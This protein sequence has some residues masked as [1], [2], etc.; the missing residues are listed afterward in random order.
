MKN[1]FWEPD[2]S[3]NLGANKHI[4]FAPAIINDEIGTSNRNNTNQTMIFLTIH[5][6]EGEEI[7]SSKTHQSESYLVH[8]EEEIKESL[9]DA[10]DFLSAMLSDYWKPMATGLHGAME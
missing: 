3:K 10:E 5:C 8:E 2:K 7:A 6:C 1:I 4:F 9:L